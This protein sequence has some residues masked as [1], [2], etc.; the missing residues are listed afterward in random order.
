MSRGPGRIER[1]I[2]EL[3]DAH[4]D[5]AFVTDE[6]A[7]HCYPDAGP[8]ER[9]HQV[10]VLRAAQKVVAN[11]PDWTVW[12]ISGM[13]TGL[14]FVNQAN[15]Q[16]Y[17]LGLMIGSSLPDIIYR[18]EKRARRRPGEW[19]RCGPGFRQKRSVEWERQF[20][21]NRAQLLAQA[22]SSRTAEQRVADHIAWRDGGPETRAAL[23]AKWK[24]NI[25]LGRLLADR[26]MGRENGKC[27]QADDVGD[28]A[29]LN[30]SA[31]AER[32]RALMVQNDPDAVRAGLADIADQL[33]DMAG[34]EE[35]R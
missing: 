34:R 24:A 13:G 4:P 17:T 32:I 3:F 9:K 31:L 28:K 7:E 6:L 8:I 23:R 1:A 21:P 29:T 25:E 33:D 30:P 27:Y 11:D 26:A 15:V 2:R 18:S 10:A 14:V 5:L 35:P 20:V 22:G 16:S 12:L 19:V